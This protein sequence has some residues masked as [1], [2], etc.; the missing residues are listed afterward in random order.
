MT[1]IQLLPTPNYS[2]SNATESCQACVSFMAETHSVWG[3]HVMG[4]NGSHTALHSASQ[5]TYPSTFGCSLVVE[6]GI[7]RGGEILERNKK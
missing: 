7:G 4:R 6:R 2:L 1:Q 3:S 5:G